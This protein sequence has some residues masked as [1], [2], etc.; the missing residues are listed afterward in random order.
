MKIAIFGLGYVGTVSSACLAKLG[1]E[2]L[3]VDVSTV[4]VDQINAAASPIVEAGLDEL[5]R[6]A[7]DDGRL[8][9]TTDVREA[10]LWADASLIC[11]GTPSRPNG[12]LD[13]GYVEG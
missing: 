2:V 4:K 8:K 12:S 1:H 6:Q 10:I 9:A 3:G 7:V 13:T 11:V 5:I